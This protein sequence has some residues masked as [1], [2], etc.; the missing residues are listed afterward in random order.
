MILLQN[1]EWFVSRLSC[2]FLGHEWVSVMRQRLAGREVQDLMVPRQG[3][4]L[5]WPE[6][7]PSRHIGNFLGP[8]DPDTT[9]A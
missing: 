2:R 3:F 7:R 6:S 1:M 8:S 9:G 4:G 5:K